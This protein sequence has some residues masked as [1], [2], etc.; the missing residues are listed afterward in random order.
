MEDVPCSDPKNIIGKCREQAPVQLDI[1][2][3]IRSG[4]AGQH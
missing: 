2:V 1:N 4:L 3:T